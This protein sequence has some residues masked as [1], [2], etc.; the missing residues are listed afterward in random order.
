MFEQATLDY[1]PATK[2]IWNTCMGVTGEA[3]LVASAVIAPMIWPQVLPRPSAVATWLTAPG[4]P[5]APQKP[6]PA[7]PMRA[8]TVKRPP[9]QITE[10]GV[11]LPRFIPLRPVLIEEPPLTGPATG[12]GGVPGG[13]EGGVG[14]R[15]MGEILRA[16]VAAVP[17]PVPAAAAPPPAQPA[18]IQRVRAGGLVRMARPISQPQPAYPRIA[19]MA[20]VSGV[21]E[22]EAI[23][24]VDGRIRDVRV[25]SGS[26]LLAPAAMEAVR[27]WVYEPT[28]LNGDP[29]EVIAPVTVTFRMK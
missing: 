10:A 14:N 16:V 28:T 26:P 17:V 6:A 12:G 15:F 22:L 3:V 25:L 20:R 1:G 23:I 27:R 7:E 2:R 13:I 18:P 5:A 29:V 24:G 9:L 4:P 11:Y 8:A 21:V 19:L